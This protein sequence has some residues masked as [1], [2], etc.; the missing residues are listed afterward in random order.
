MTIPEIREQMLAAAAQTFDPAIAE[1]LKV[2]EQHLHRRAPVRRAPRHCRP[3]T[4]ATADAIKEYAAAHPRAG[5]QIMS[6]R[7]GVSIGRV[8]EVLAGKRI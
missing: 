6:A 5:Y 8:S 7:F 2:W 3:L 4:D 1:Q